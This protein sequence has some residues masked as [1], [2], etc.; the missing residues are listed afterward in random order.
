M[1][2]KE[3]IKKIILILAIVL[4][5]LNI[6]SLSAL[7]QNQQEHSQIINSVS[8]L[9]GYKEWK[10]GDEF[11]LHNP[12]YSEMSNF[13][14]ESNLSEIDLVLKEAKTQGIRCGVAEVILG[15]DLLTKSLIV[16][17]TVD[18]GLCFYE[19]ETG[20]RVIPSLGKHYT[21][22]VEENPYDETIFDDTIV[23]ILKIW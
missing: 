12:L 5:I 23:D 11:E 7:L 16:F 14:K 22:C 4:T 21:D 1:L 20:Y 19:S 10:E 3:K 2:K 18:E 8:T 15:E 9:E 13:L 17:Q 6:Y